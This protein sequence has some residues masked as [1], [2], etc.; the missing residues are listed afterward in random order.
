MDT[1][2]IHGHTPGG[3]PVAAPI[4]GWVRTVY[5]LAVEI[6]TDAA[7]VSEAPTSLGGVLLANAGAVTIYL[8]GAGVT[9]ESG[10]PLAAG[11][12]IGWSTLGDVSILYAVTAS[13]TG[14]LRVL[15]GV[16]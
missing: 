2:L 11:T 9:S 5:T 8:G 1:T 3:R 12:A 15:G 14:D 10:F 4:G 7:Q 13:G 16:A 6:G